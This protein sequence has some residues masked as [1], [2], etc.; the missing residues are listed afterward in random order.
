MQ[1]DLSLTS[2]SALP[3]KVEKG[4]TRLYALD[5]H[6][7]RRLSVLNLLV[8]TSGSDKV[9]ALPLQFPC[10]SLFPIL[11]TIQDLRGSMD[12]KIDKKLKI[13]C[14]KI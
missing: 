5:G 2:K 6:A 3:L 14:N 12:Y 1:T 13:F 4:E 9:I 10:R 11:P 8:S 7:E